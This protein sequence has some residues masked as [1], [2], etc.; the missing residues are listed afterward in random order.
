MIIQTNAVDMSTYQIKNL[1]IPTDPNDAVSKS[2]AE[3][4]LNNRTWKDPVRV[5]V[6]SNVNIASPG[7]TL[8]GVTMAA[9]D[10]VLLYGQSTQSQNG[11][12]VWNGATSPMTR[13]AD[14]D[15]DT[16]IRPGTTYVI[17][18][19]S[20]ADRYAILITDGIVTIGTS[21]LTFV[22]MSNTGQ[23]YTA[24][25]GLQLVSGAFSIKLDTASG[26]LVTATGLKLDPSVSARKFA[27]AVGDGAA[28]Q[29]AVTH[30]FGN[31]NVLIGMYRT[32]DGQEAV[33]D[34]T[35]RTV[36]GFNLNFGTAPTTGAYTIVVQG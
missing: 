3:Q 29:V 33:P 1:G 30:N 11:A 2:F 4:L 23:V 15:T 6:G 10:R 8:D 16:E 28:T 22:V 32:S 34:T 12:Y 21:A 13:A 35:G 7:A 26:L 36:N 9:G 17:T 18:E 25:N 5:G 20:T 27:A 19:G 24:S 31:K 14:S